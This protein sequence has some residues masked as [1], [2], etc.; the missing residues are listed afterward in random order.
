M[1]ATILT[2]AAALATLAAAPATSARSTL[3]KDQAFAR[4]SK[5]L[6]AHGARDVIARG[7]N[8]GGLAQYP[9]PT[10][11]AAV[12]KY[13]VKGDIAVGVQL[14]F[15]GSTGPTKVQRVWAQRCV[16]WGVP[17]VPVKR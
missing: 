1:K 11:G 4:A 3:T 2:L 14:W 12:F 10:G 7:L 5:C 17:L 15:S 8:L 6:K 16:T 13:V 9:S